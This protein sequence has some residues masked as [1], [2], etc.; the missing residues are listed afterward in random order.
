MRRRL[1]E[2]PSELTGLLERA[3]SLAANEKDRG[4]ILH[5]LRSLQESEGAYPEAEASFREALTLEE[6]VFGKDHP[7]YGVSLHAL[8]VVLERQ[9]QNREAEA[10][11]RQALEVKEK[12]LGMGH[13]SLCPTLVNLA[14]VLADRGKAEEGEPLIQRT[15]QISLEILG[16]EHP[17]TAQILNM[18]AQMQARLG[19]PQAPSTA[20][21]AIQ[22]LQATLGAN[23]PITQ[24]VTPTLERIAS[25]SPASPQN[26]I[27]SLAGQARDGAIAALN[28]KIDREE[29]SARIEAVA[30]KAA[31]GEE[32]GSPWDQLAAYLRAVVALLRGEPR[33]EVPAAFAE[34]FSAI[35]RVAKDGG[36]EP[37]P[38]GGG[39]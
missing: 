2:R 11:L 28:G 15:L 29:L 31:E 21:Q 30:E 20:R 23:H 4:H 19:R 12:V 24:Q 33:V 5:E 18:L 8:A 27:Q 38:V 7:E 37:A 32:A 6:R 3:L 36:D 16:A 1:G 13:P 22:A 39:I 25:G 10:L 26:Q 9:G 14:V 34:H 17:T 35:E